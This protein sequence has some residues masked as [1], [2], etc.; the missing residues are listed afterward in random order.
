MFNSISW[1]LLLFLNFDKFYDTH[2]LTI[3]KLYNLHGE[4][5]IRV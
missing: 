3:T 2:P 1:Q 4:L 5:E